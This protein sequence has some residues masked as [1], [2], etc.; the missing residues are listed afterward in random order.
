AVWIGDDSRS[1]V[2]VTGELF[3]GEGDSFFRISCAVAKT[4]TDRD[5]VS[6]SK[7]VGVL[8]ATIG[9]AISSTCS[10]INRCS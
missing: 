8:V 10:D 6:S 9:C 3:I 5:F 2:A 1:S 7:C 4:D